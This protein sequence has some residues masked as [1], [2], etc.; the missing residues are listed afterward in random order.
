[1]R[2]AFQC[3][4]YNRKTSS[5]EQSFLFG[6]WKVETNSSTLAG[7]PTESSHDTELDTPNVF[8]RFHDCDL[9]DHHFRLFVYRQ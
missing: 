7:T 4:L 5:G 6:I 8:I 1:M 9:A 3:F 2:I